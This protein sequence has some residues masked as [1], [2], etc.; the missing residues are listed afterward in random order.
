[1][2]Y[3]LLLL[4]V[5]FIGVNIYYSLDLNATKNKILEA[6]YHKKGFVYTIGIVEGIFLIS[7]SFWAY[8]HEPKTLFHLFIFMCI[9]A[10]L[11]AFIPVSEFISSNRLLLFN[12]IL[13][14]IIYWFIMASILLIIIK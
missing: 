14:T 12:T 3:I 11:W 13:T 6:V 7:G 8:G 5:F 2:I 10:I 9:W 1:M 4:S